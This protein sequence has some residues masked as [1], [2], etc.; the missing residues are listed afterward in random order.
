[1]HDLHKT[2]DKS[3]MSLLRI[4]NERQIEQFGIDQIARELWGGPVSRQYPVYVVFYK[5]CVVGF[6][7]ALQLTCIFPALHPEKMK[8]REFIKVTKSLVTE[9]KRHVGFPVFLLC[10][11]ATEIGP[12]G[13]RLMRLKKAAEEYYVYDEDAP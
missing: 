8:P 9:M 4:D 5:G 3:A 1:M 10:K 6:F 2:P 11:K 7:Q 12:R 13:M